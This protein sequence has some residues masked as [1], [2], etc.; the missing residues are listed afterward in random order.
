[1]VRTPEGRI[2]CGRGQ[3]ALDRSGE[4]VCS[5]VDGGAVVK[6]AD[7]AIRCQGACEPASIQLCERVPAGR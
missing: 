3:C 2:R 7:G 6:E 4:Y 1:V 5:N